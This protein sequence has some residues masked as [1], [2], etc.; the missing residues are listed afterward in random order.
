MPN[1]YP[2]TFAN[3]LLGPL[4]RLVGEIT[5]TDPANQPSG[6]GGVNSVTAGDASV[7]V[8]GTVV[9]PTVAV[10]PLGVTAAKIAAL[11]VTAAKMSSG[12]ATA[13][14]VA[15]ADGA[16]NVTYE[17]AAVGSVTAGD[18]SV[19]VGGTA[20]APTIE[21]ADLATI[22]A[23]H[24]ASGAV[25]LNGKKI[26]GLANGASA[27][28]AAAFGQIPLALPPNGAAGGG[29][30]GTYPNP[31]VVKVQGVAA[32]AT[33]PT[34]GQVWT[35]ADAT[36]GAWADQAGFAPV[37]AAYNG[38]GVSI[39]NGATGQVTW[40]SLFS[41]TE[42]LDRTDPANPLFLSTGTYAITATLG[43]TFPLTA[44]GSCV[45]YLFEQEAGATSAAAYTE[46]PEL[47]ITVSVVVVVTDVSQPLQALV[48]NFDG[49]S[50]RFFLLAAGVIVQ[51]A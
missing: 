51:L 21:T 35:A 4:R 33:P 30:G 34:A 14:K 42:L 24:P 22:A 37:Q 19:V 41:G 6:S 39:A 44:G 50:A 46:K 28:D 47:G 38:S 49:V 29:L 27:Q 20:S 40:D 12:A 11:A 43:S 23:L 32:S 3:R 31:S 13:G 16:G 7:T 8:A 5:F 26:T 2:A 17:G 15:T 1:P 18:A 10:A 45:A 9:D 36:H 48:E 25:A